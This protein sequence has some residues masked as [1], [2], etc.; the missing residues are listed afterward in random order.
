MN[1]V[2]KPAPKGRTGLF[3]FFI[4]LVLSIVFLVLE[5][6]AGSAEA[7]PYSDFLTKVTDKKITQVCLLVYFIVYLYINCTGLYRCVFD[8][9]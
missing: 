1:N 7:I 9:R 6:N 8:T 4:F 5:S 2:N 3:V